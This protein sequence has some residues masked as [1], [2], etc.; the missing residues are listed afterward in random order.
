M[1]KKP[2]HFG[3]SFREWSVR[4]PKRWW[5]MVS[6]L[7]TAIPFIAGIIAFIIWG[8]HIEPPLPTWI[9]SLTSA[10][11][12]L[13][14][15]LSFLAFDRVRIERDKA[16]EESENRELKINPPSIIVK[17]KTEQD[18]YYLE[19]T[20]IGETAEFECQI[21]IIEDNTGNR[22]GQL[23]LGYWQIGTSS[24]P[25]IMNTDRIR[26]ASKETEIPPRGSQAIV[27]LLM[28]L[29]LYYYDKRLMHQP[30]FWRSTVWTGEGIIKPEYR[31]RI[32]ITSIPSM[33]EGKFI[34]DYRLDLSGLTEL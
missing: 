17:P 5:D 4:V 3:V 23:Y 33:R 2:N 19:V 24:K 1:R 28:E 12:I 10:G 14:I 16:R 18:I 20:N 6:I 15:I 21:E 30:P 31:L 27:D 11:A 9:I 22:K 7:L 29:H 25:T 13:F 34:R 26:I 8:R 32:T